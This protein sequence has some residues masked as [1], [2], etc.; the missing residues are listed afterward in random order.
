MYRQ[1][2]YAHKKKC[3]FINSFNTLVVSQHTFEA[4]LQE[5]IDM[6]KTMVLIM[7]KLNTLINDKDLD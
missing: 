6:K 1:G 2:L 5:N 7:N 4:L 3:P